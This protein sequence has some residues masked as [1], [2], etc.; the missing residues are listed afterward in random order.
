MK[1]ICAIYIYIYIYINTYKYICMYIYA[2]PTYLAQLSIWRG[3]LDILDIYRHS[4]KHSKNKIDS[5]VIKSHQC[6]LE[7]S[8]AKLVELNSGF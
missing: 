3:G 6:S 2:I 5:K 1:Y 8:H 4:I 7:R